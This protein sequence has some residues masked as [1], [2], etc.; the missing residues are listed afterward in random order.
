MTDAMTDLGEPGDNLAKVLRFVG[1]S[2]LLC[3]KR[4]S[5]L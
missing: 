4:R 1:W 2:V 5:N 3:E